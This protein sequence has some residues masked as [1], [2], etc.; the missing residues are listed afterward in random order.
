M[1]VPGQASQTNSHTHGLT[2]A[3][4][5]NLHYH[6]Q[7]FFL[8]A[9]VSFFFNLLRVVVVLVVLVLVFSFVKTRCPR[10]GFLKKIFFVLFL[11][12]F[13]K[14]QKKTLQPAAF[15]VVVFRDRPRV[16]SDSVPGREGRGRRTQVSSINRPEVSLFVHVRELEQLPYPHTHSER[17]IPYALSALNDCVALRSLLK[18]VL[19]LRPVS[20]PR[21]H[22]SPSSSSARET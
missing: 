8:S 15:F 14:E 17:P 21:S 11:F 7:S 12:F 16:D 5:I 4:H 18:M 2:H 19:L 1:H 10:R 22:S 6:T 20:I 3:Q 9:R 13:Q